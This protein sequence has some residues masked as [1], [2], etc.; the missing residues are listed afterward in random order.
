MEI[1]APREIKPIIK[2]TVYLASFMYPASYATKEQIEY[3]NKKG[4]T[5]I[6]PIVNQV[7][8]AV[9]W[10]GNKKTNWCKELP[11]TI[12]QHFQERLGNELNNNPTF[13]PKN[14]NPKLL[15][16]R[17]MEQA[18]NQCTFPNILPSELAL[19][20]DNGAQIS[21]TIGGFPAE[22]TLQ[23]KGD[24]R[25]EYELT[26]KSFFA[27][28]FATYGMHPASSEEEELA[29]EQNIEELIDAELVSEQIRGI[30]LNNQGLLFLEAM[31]FPTTDF[32]NIV[33]DYIHGKNGCPNRETFVRSLIDAKIEKVEFL[34]NRETGD[35]KRRKINQEK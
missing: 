25:K 2:V 20:Y 11:H 4:I 22:I 12:V 16:T 35:L 9:V 14:Q 30:A 6:L 29:Q 27:D 17:L 13:F 34:E 8:K 5:P 26:L 18:Y 15:F 24:F 33:A 19:N 10:E 21:L 3:L 7:H 28:P 1:N 32:P 23:C 31:D